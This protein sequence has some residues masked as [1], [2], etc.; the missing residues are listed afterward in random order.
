MI[1]N[2]VTYNLSGVSEPGDKLAFLVP[3][4]LAL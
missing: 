1:K 4:A 2:T 3:E